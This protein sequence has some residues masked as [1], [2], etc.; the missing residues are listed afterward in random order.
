TEYTVPL[1][2]KGSPSTKKTVTYEEIQAAPTRDVNSLASTTAGVYQKD[3]GGGLNIRG[4]R[5]DATTYFVDGVRVRG[6]TGLPQ[7]GIEQITVTTGGLEAQYGDVTGGVIAITTRGAS[8]FY[9]GGVEFQTSEFLDAYGYRL[10]TGSVSGPIYTKR[11]S[12]GKKFGQPLAGFFL[13]A[14]YQYDKDPDPSAIPIY[15]VKDDIL[16]SAKSS[17]LVR[18]PSGFTYIHRSH[19]WTYDSLDKVKA[20]PNVAADAYRFNGRLDLQPVKN[21]TVAFGGS[22]ERSK[23]RDFID[24]Y[25]LMDYDNNPQTINTNWRAWGRITQRFV[26][27]G[28]EGASSALKSAYYS[29]QADYS[30]NMQTSQDYRLKDDLF[31]YGHV[32]KFT[33]YSVPFYQG[34]A[35]TR[36]G[37][38]DSLVFTQIA[39]FDTLYDFVPGD[40]NPE[41]SAYTSQ[42]YD[43]TDPLGTSGYQDSYG[44]L[45]LRGALVN[46]DNRNPLTVYG[47]WGTTGRLRNFYGETDNSQFR[48]TARGSVDINNHNIILGMEYEQRTDRGWS[49]N[50]S[51]LWSLMRQLSN[52]RLTGFDT[53]TAVITSTTSGGTPI[54]FITYPNANYSPTTNLDGQVAPGFFEKVRDHLGIAYTDTIQIDALDPSQ[55][56]LDLFS[57]DE[58]LDFGFVNYY[59]YTYT[60]EKLTGQPAYEDY[61]IKKDSKNNYLREVDAFRP[62]Y[63]AGYIQDRFTFKDI[64]FNV[65]LRVDRF[66]ANQKVLRDKYLLYPT[67]T[68]GDPAVLDKIPNA[69]IPSNIGSDFAVY[70]NNVQNPTAIVGFRDGDQWYNAEGTPIT[71]LSPL[72]DNGTGGS[73]I[74]PF[75]KNYSDVQQSIFRPEVFTDYSPQINLMPRIAFSFPISDEAILRAH[76]DVLTQRP[77]NSA[78]LRLNPGS[79]GSLARGISGTISNPDLKPERT[80]EYEVT[81]EQRL[82]RSS[83]LSIAAF[84]RE[85]RDQIQIINVQY[86]YPITYSTYGNIDFGTVKG[87]SFAYD[88]RRTN[89][90]RMNFSY[91]LQF[92]DGTGSSPFTSAGVLAQQGQTNLRQ[93]QPLS[94]DQR[95]TFVATFDY[96]YGRGKDY[97]GPVMWGRQV[98]AEAGLN[99]I[100]RAGSGT[101]YSRQSNITP[102]A[103]FTSTAN[104]RSVLTGSINGSRLPWQFRI[105]ARVDKNFEIKMGK[106]QDGE[107]RNPVAANIYLL[108]QNVLDAQN[109]LG[110][111]A[112]TGDPAD[113]G[114]LSSPGAQAFIDSKVN[115]QSYIDLYEIAQ[116]NPGNYQLPR[117]IRLGLQL[118]F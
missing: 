62:N 91:T 4:A 102:T 76:Y 88:L 99:L 84:Y 33:T 68:A 46:G 32:G 23:S 89:N 74:Q 115:P 21:V 39:N 31:R 51:N 94:F 80:V 106:K 98:L 22:L 109:I 97:N 9:N 85:L 18:D 14:E 29:I 27:E 87:L 30:R 25:S 101:P 59:G 2:D 13:A 111:Y 114:Y 110:V 47:L 60:G 48:L 67:Y 117:R 86:A 58:L 93:P 57:P 75:V 95:H 83:A 41:I 77:Q 103:D 5:E 10:A 43:I 118:N 82:S 73:G 26:S 45:L 55:L 20:R 79:Y 71:D 3:E 49:V 8:P 63:V 16:E 72:L 90:V 56:S 28:K 100:L 116:N 15:K 113:D 50:P 92:A 34:E 70:V 1:I 64:T 37:L 40:A 12:A 17:P 65:G 108:V 38:S 7:R 19:Y 11:D 107:A 104:S 69:V 53:T 78:L 6:G 24:I 105:D 112:A 42:Y 44:T 61:F 52:S 66:D 81:F 54:T 35:I 36:P 96:H